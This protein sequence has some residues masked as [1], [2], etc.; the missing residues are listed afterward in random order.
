MLTVYKYE[1]LA[2]KPHHFTRLKPKYLLLGAAILLVL[3]S[4]G[5]R[6][7]A[8]DFGPSAFPPPGLR[9]A[10]PLLIS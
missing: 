2:L 9:D 3:T 4:F 7:C 6:V 1:G 10:T 5:V 8:V